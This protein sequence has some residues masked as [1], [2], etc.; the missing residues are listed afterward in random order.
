M[1]AAIT[2]LPHTLREI[3][4]RGLHNLRVEIFCRSVS[5]SE[6]V[7]AGL[8]V[9]IGNLVLIRPSSHFGHSCLKSAVFGAAS[10]ASK[11]E[12]VSI[13][14]S[15]I[16]S[17]SC[18]ASSALPVM[19]AICPLSAQKFNGLC[20]Q[21]QVWTML[22]T[23]GSPPGTVKEMHILGPHLLNHKLFHFTP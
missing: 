6:H 15:E 7:S 13:E 12:L 8:D 18:V 21:T 20:T 17:S 4:V 5:S 3:L 14:V 23:Y 1:L 10:Q 16:V 2:F 9:L 11:A 22:R 19:H